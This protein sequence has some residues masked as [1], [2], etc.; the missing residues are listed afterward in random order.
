[1]YEYMILKISS[2][3]PDLLLFLILVFT[4]QTYIFQLPIQVADDWQGN[5]SRYS[6]SPELREVIN[7]ISEVN[8]YFNIM[9]LN[10]YILNAY[11]LF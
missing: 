9:S 5:R 2:L 11:S 7:I 6:I 1:M 4:S 10:E 3:F 8:I